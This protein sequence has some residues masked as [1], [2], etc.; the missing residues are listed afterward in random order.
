M[1]KIGFRVASVILRV[2]EI[3]FGVTEMVL[4]IGEST[5]GTC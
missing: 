3:V 4:E 1:R 5:P 2:R